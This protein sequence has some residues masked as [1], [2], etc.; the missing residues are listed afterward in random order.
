MT[1][2]ASQESQFGHLYLGLEFDPQPVFRDLAPNCYPWPTGSAFAVSLSEE[3]LVDPTKWSH[4]GKIIIEYFADDGWPIEFPH[5]RK[6]GYFPACVDARA[7]SYFKMLVQTSIPPWRSW[8]ELDW[9]QFRRYGS[10]R[11][12]VTKRQS[13]GLRN[14]LKKIAS[15]QPPYCHTS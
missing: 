3:E 12:Y 1:C 15:R 9:Y 8:T 6:V 5:G 11:L 7:D 13:S 4:P 2:L 14:E 10:S